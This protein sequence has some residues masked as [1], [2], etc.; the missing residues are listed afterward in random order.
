MT[1]C[2]SFAGRYCIPE[3][4]IEGAAGPG[5]FHTDKTVAASKSAAEK[6]ESGELNCV[7]Q[8][9]D[10]V[11]TIKRRYLENLGGEGEKE[12]Q[13]NPLGILPR[14]T[15]TGSV[16]QERFLDLAVHF[17]QSLPK[18]Q[19]G[20]PVLLILDG[21]ASRWSIAAIR[22]LLAHNVYVFYLPGHSSV[23]SQ[24]NDMGANQRFHS[25]LE[26]VASQHRRGGG[27]EKGSVPYFNRM[28]VEAWRMYVE[29]E[30]KQLQQLGYNN[31]TLGWCASGL[32]P[33]NP[34]C[35]GWEDAINTLGKAK[36]MQDEENE[37]INAAASKA[38]AAANS[39]TNAPTNLPRK[40]REYEPRAIEDAAKLAPEEKTV[41]LEGFGAVDPFHAAFLVIDA[42]LAAWKEDWHLEK[43]EKPVPSTEQQKIAAKLVGLVSRTPCQDRPCGRK[44][45]TG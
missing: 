44:T 8:S 18:A 30:H 42:M 13:R 23:W 38:A 11:I 41:L 21:H 31:A 6:A 5:L 24:P 3:L 29:E 28:F 19:R 27:S 22:Y 32:Q 43:T 14:T 36:K 26:R 17:V 33:F 7:N 9:V 15:K 20:K 16:T 10:E 12:W 35:T 2:H 37:A 45:G 39:E 25:C 1:F 34:F 40:R 4:G